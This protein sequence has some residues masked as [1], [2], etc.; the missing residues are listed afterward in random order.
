MIPISYNYRNLVVRWKTTLITAS[1][2]MLVV[3][4]LIVMLAFVNGVQSVCAQSGQPENVIV[5]KEGTTDEVLSEMGERLVRR[6]ELTPGVSRDE[7]DRPLSS[8]ELFMAVNQ[9]NETTQAYETLQVRGV[10]PQAVRVHSHVRITQGRMF[11]RNAREVVLGAAVARKRQLALDQEIPIG[12]SNWKVVGIFEARGSVFESEVWG[13]LDQLAGEFHRRNVYTSVVLRCP[14]PAA[15]ADVVRDIDG[16]KDIRVEAQTEPDYF[17][18]QGQHNE[19]I[20]RGALGITAFMAVGAVFGVANTM[21]AAIGERVK[22]I[23]VMRLLGFSR[24][25][26]LASFLF[27]AMFTSVIGAA[28]GSLLGYGVNGLTLSTALA[29]SATAKSVAFAFQV[30]ASIIVAAWLFA[31]VMGIVGGLLPAMSA[32]SVRPLDAMQ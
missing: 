30:D 11:R 14:D 7:N 17:K 4:A 2:F 23:A 31:I 32:M 8:C 19:M 29:Q 9:R 20:R 28:L 26:I 5:L 1:G 21:F 10:L 18:K 13:D 24:L 15:A 12:E 27:E 22:D 16:R 3:T 25:E 6:I